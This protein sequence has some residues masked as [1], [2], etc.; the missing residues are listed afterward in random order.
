VS[1]PGAS[2]RDYVEQLG[3][4]LRTRDPAALRGF[5]SAQAAR[6]GDERQVAQIDGQSLDE[7]ETLMHR[8]TLARSDLSEYHAASRAWL[9]ARGIQPPAI[10]RGR[11]N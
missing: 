4:V 10:D 11:R 8:M 1:A 3:V 5:L 6:F 9:M 2:D 7:I